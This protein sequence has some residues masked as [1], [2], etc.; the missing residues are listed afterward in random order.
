MRMKTQLI[1]IGTFLILSTPAN[2]GP[3]KDGQPCAKPDDCAVGLTCVD[4]FCGDPNALSEK[5]IDSAYKR[6]T[7]QLHDISE[8]AKKE[9][10]EKK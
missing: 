1:I 9:M 4:G 8:A 2:A 10:E 5:W 7:Q 6:A 3:R